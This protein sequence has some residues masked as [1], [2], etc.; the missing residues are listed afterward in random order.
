[1]AVSGEVAAQA[2]N[3]SIGGM[4]LGIITA[5]IVLFLVFGSLF[6]MA[7]PLASALVALGTAISLNGVLSHAIGMPDFSTQLVGL[8]GLGDATGAGTGP[9]HP[10]RS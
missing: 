9:E 1:V 7:M 2:N 5:G 8:I 3:P 4:G 6:A 10:S